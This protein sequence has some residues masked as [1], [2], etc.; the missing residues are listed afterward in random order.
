TYSGD[1]TYYDVGLGSCGSTDSNSDYVAALNAP[2]MAN[3]ANP[4]K[5][6]QCGKRI[7]V[8]N[9]ANQ[10]SVTVT[11]VDTC[12]PCAFGSVDLSPSAFD[13]IADLSLGRIPIEW[14]Y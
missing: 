10:K 7:K 4:N 3:G 13:E 9:P 6:P 12:P 8:V 5:N 1:G 11:I 14:S 2:Q